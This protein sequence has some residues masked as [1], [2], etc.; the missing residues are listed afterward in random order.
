[1]KIEEILVRHCAC[2]PPRL[3]TPMMPLGIGGQV[4]GGVVGDEAI[5]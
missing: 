1:L 5:S 3:P 4:A 2:P